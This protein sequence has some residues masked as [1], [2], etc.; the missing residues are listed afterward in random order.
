MSQACALTSQAVVPYNFN[1]EML[2]LICQ[3]EG[4]QKGGFR[5]NAN[6]SLL[7]REFV[8]FKSDIAA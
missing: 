2:A 5:T 7:S 4:R 6:T 1:P 3:G 8:F